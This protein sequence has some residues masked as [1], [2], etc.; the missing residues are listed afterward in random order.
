M[1][2]LNMEEKSRLEIAVEE[3]FCLTREPSWRFFGKGITQKT[4][5]V[6]ATGV[7]LTQKNTLVEAA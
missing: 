6:S 5:S 1:I 2:I 7:K 4:E 3:L